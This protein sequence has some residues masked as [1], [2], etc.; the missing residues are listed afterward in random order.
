M[1]PLERWQDFYMIVGSSAGA[2]IGLQFVVITLIAEM[3][4]TRS[5]AQT[6]HAFTTPS[7]VHFG[8]VLLLSALISA[9]WNE[10]ESAAILWGLIGLC[11]IIYT[12]VVV[13]RM[14]RQTAYLPVFEDWLFHVLFP[15]AAYLALAASARLALSQARPALFSVAASSLLLLFTGIHNAWDIVTYQVFVRKRKHQQAEQ[16]GELKD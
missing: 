4:V 6:G 10:I 7:V 16:A 12:A 8:V 9:P 13:R 5:D 1:N 14:R 2:L 15:L 3:P 11:G